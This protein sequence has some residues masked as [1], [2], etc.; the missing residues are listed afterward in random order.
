MNASLISPA[1][2]AADFD[3][4]A[5][6]GTIVTVWAHPD[7]ETYVA[8]GLVAMARHLGSGVTCITATDGDFAK[9][10]ARRRLVA[11]QRRREL[12]LALC[13]L[14]VSDR[15]RLGLPDGACGDIDDRTG[16]AMIADVLRARRPDT[17]ITFGPD[18][19]TG[20]PDHRAVGR[21]TAE[22][23]RRECPHARVLV[24]SLTPQMVEDDRDINDRFDVYAPGLPLPHD[25]SELALDLTVRGSWLDLKLAAL[26]AHASQTSGLIDM[27][28]L[29]RYRRWVSREPLMD[30]HR[31][32]G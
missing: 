24:P 19:L 2:L 10:A 15:V 17:V 12:E 4:I 13:L 32:R 23:V 8:G 1:E 25:P 18:G 21:W 22:A 14:G 11:V 28:G 3:R 7:D 31:H 16:V 20:H 27:I 30:L 9:T 5:A 26:R 6:L 29:P